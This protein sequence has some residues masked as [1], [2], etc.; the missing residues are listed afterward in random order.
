MYG[1]SLTR[2]YL[3]PLGN[4]HV[5]TSCR[6]IL[7]CSLLL[8]HFPTYLKFPYYYFQQESILNFGKYQLMTEIF[9]DIEGQPGAVLRIDCLF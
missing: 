5:H 9:Q 6:R 1:R 7:F 2:Q 8:R 3:Y 4:L